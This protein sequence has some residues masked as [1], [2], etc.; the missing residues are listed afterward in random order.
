MSVEKKENFLVRSLALDIL[1]SWSVMAKRMGVGSS[2][3]SSPD[4][5]RPKPRI[6]STPLKSGLLQSVMT[7]K[8]AVH[9]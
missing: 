2:L 6:P 7:P 9:L 4:F 5:G 8:G 1:F 3:P